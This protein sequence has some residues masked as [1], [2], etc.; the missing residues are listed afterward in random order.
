[1]KRILLLFVFLALCRFASGQNEPQAMFLQSH[2]QS[3]TAPFSVT[4]K[5]TSWSPVR[6]PFVF[7]RWEFG[8]GTVDSSGPIVAHTYAQKGIF[9]VKLTV[10]DQ[11]GREGSYT[12]VD[13]KMV[14]IGT[15]L[16]L[17]PNTFLCNE[18]QPVFRNL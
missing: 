6:S 8:D 1:M 12:A 17:P 4:F 14:R 18:P 15:A 10:R 2:Y 13:Y 9:R 3:C 7:W 16:Q 11:A 5:D